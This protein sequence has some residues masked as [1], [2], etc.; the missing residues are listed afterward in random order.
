MKS[1]NIIWLVGPRF[2]SKFLREGL[3]VRSLRMFNRALLG[4]LLW[5]YV[6]EIEAW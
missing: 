4:K 6:H 3:G 5:R 2:A 1:S